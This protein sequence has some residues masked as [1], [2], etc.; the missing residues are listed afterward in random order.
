MIR[1]VSPTR[2]LRPL[3]AL[4]TSSEQ[5]RQAADLLAEIA[6]D[7]DDLDLPSTRLKDPVAE[8]YAERRKATILKAQRS[9][10]AGLRLAQDRDDEDR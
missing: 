5:I 8:A 6:G 4:R 9:F 7:A 2:Q 1:P 10:V 3:Q